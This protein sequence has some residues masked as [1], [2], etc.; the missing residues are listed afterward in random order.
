MISLKYLWEN[1]IEDVRQLSYKYF[2]IKKKVTLVIETDNRK[3]E[4][5]GYV[6][7]NEPDIFSKDEGAEIS[8]ICPQYFF[9]AKGDDGENVSMFSS[10]E[11]SF[12]FPFSNES[13]SEN[14]IEV[15]KIKNVAEKVIF[16]NGDAETGIDITIHSLGDAKMITIYNTKTGETMQIDTDKIASYTGSGIKRG[17]DISICTIKGKKSISLIRE[18][19]R[20]NILNCLKKGAKWFQ[21]S[22]GDNVFAYTAEE[23]ATNLQI[24]IVNGT[25]Y[26]GV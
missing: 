18:G 20:I 1:S 10:I 16:Y 21:I 23:G 7:S 19:K 25:L 2:P 11:P 8:I 5:E 4:I 22:K 13:V 6:E 15:G 17:D 9:S 14:Q 24:K 26:E 3:A 12:E